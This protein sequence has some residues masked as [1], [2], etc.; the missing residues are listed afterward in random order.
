ML[1]VGMR[2]LSRLCL[3]FVKLVVFLGVKILLGVGE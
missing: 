1:I 2:L 3:N